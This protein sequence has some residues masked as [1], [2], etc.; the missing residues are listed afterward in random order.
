M[1]AAGSRSHNQYNLFSPDNR[2]TNSWL[3]ALMCLIYN[4]HHKLVIDARRASRFLL[5]GLS[6]ENKKT[7]IFA[8]SAPLASAASGR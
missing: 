3:S 8:S 4:D 2:K 7:I 5:F 6:A 1:I